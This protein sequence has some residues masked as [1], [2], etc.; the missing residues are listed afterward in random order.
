MPG[1]V[2]ELVGGLGDASLRVGGRDDQQDAALHHDG[3]VLS[4]TQSGLDRKDGVGLDP[5]VLDHSG[6]HDGE[7][8]PGVGRTVVR[9]G[10]GD[11]VTGPRH[12]ETQGGVGVAVDGE[13]DGQAG[14]VLGSAGVPALNHI[15][16]VV[17]EGQTGDGTLAPQ[18]SNNGQEISN[19]GG[20]E[21][22]V[23]VGEGL[24]LVE[25]GPGDGA[26]QAVIAILD[27]RCL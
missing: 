21:T 12:V 17:R 23:R 4:R 2:A 9:P 10:P 16:D 19:S 18:H 5:Q 8:G 24:A 22:V 13:T 20:V 6:R 25:I 7:L 3:S 1:D 11:S 14:A 26:D 27:S 15:V